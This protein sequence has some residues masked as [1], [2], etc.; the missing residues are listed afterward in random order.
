MS[1]AGVDGITLHKITKY[2]DIKRKKKRHMD[3]DLLKMLGSGSVSG[4]GFN[5]S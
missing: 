2:A 3:P 4:F 1:V 5:A